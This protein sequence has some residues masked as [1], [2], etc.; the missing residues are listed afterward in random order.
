MRTDVETKCECGRCRAA[1]AGLGPGPY[2]PAE[3]NQFNQYVTSSQGRAAWQD[4]PEVKH[5]QAQLDQAQRA[6]DQAHDAWAAAAAQTAAVALRI[7]NAPMRVDWDSMQQHP[8][9]PAHLQTEYEQATAAR[10]AAWQAREQAGQKLTEARIAYHV[11]A[12][13]A[14]ARTRG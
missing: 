9:I 10:D 11:A 13:H 7:R 14:Q 12:K 4:D 6:F 5:A 2:T 1:R 3:F 8:V